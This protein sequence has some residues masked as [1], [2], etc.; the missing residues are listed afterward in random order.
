MGE[1]N[2]LQDD[3]TE[4]VCKHAKFFF[5]QGEWFKESNNPQF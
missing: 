1:R 3:Q 2:C 5:N 4:I